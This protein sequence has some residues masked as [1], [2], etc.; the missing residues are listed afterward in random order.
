[1][2]DFAVIQRRLGRRAGTS[3]IVDIQG[4]AYRLFLRPIEPVDILPRPYRV[5][6]A[7]SYILAVAAGG[8]RTEYADGRDYR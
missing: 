2:T 5:P 1:M 8:V 6:T 7:T 4:V 3:L